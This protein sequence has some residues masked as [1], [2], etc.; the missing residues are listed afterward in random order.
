MDQDCNNDA[1]NKLSEQPADRKR[2]EEV[3]KSGSFNTETKIGDKARPE[4]E[5]R[6]EEEEDG[7]QIEA[8]EEGGG[9]TVGSE[10]RGSAVKEAP[11]NDEKNEMT[12]I[13]RSGYTREGKT[14]G[15]AL[16][17]RVKEKKKSENKEDAVSAFIATADEE[18]Y[19]ASALREVVEKYPW[20]QRLLQSAVMGKIARNRGVTTK[21]KDVGEVEAR[22]IGSNLAPCL[23]SRI[24]V[25]A[26]VDQW[27]LQNAAVGE[28]FEEFPWMNDM[29]MAVGYGVVRAAPWG[30]Q[31]RV[32]VGAVTSM[33]DLLTDIYVTY[34]FSTD[35]TKQGYFQ[36][37]LTSLAASI[38]IQ[39]LFTWG[40]NRKLGK[41][42]LLMEWI[43]IL[44]GYK[45]A[46]DA[47]RVATGAK[48]PVGTPMNPMVEMTYMK[49]IEMFAEAIPAV[50]IQLMAI[51]TT[52]QEVEIPNS[53]W[54]SLAT[55]ILSTGFISATI[56]YDWDT[57]PTRREQVPDFY[58]YVPIEAFKRTLVFAA[59]ILLTS[60]LLLI[61]CMT[62]VLLGLF[63]KRFAF[64]YICADLGLYMIIKLLR[65]DFWYWTPIGV[66]AEIVMSFFSRV[67]VKIVNDFTSIVQFR[68]PNELGGA[69]WVFGVALTMGSL[70]VAI[71]MTGHLGN[72]ERGVAIAMTILIYVLPLTVVSFVVFFLTIERSYWKTFFSLQKGK[73]LTVKNFREGTEAVKAKY[74]FKYSKHHWISIEE[75]VRAWV[76]A[77]W[78]KWEEEK[79]EWF[80]DAMK[81]KVPVDYIPTA[82]AKQRESL[83]R[84]SVDAEAIGLGVALRASIRRA[85]IELGGDIDIARVVPSSEE[86]K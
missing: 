70:P 59:T 69:Y 63:G 39:L 22:V 28:L 16:I 77:N 54:I 58:G 76:E 57:D 55:S 83:R 17:R 31:A 53:A 43:P 56:S 26:A 62:I 75:E 33:F 36:A 10:E 32:T 78:E 60:G 19:N 72:A 2:A 66:Y 40:Q 65:R 9:A 35:S 14:L 6:E 20:F 64:S 85:S 23:K 29:F 73:D 84:A 79:P 11:L 61:R 82:E 48:Q 45:P 52:D 4:G 71:V 80:D 7:V 51:A 68:H 74:T 15:E 18:G 25:P 5:E 8:N 30:L 44:L 42:K 46:V 50:I 47:Y 3:A 1:E 34:M 86:D 38:G 24:V 12:L 13:S 81:A 21:L 27:R 41:K 49:G 37:S 67:L